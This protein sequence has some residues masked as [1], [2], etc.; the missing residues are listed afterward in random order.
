MLVR[1]WCL[2]LLLVVVTLVKLHDDL[3]G[4]MILTLVIELWLVFLYRYD[5]FESIGLLYPEVFL[6]FIA[7][8]L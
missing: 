3:S 8:E 5:A 4:F 2:Q 1:K 7:E 6:L